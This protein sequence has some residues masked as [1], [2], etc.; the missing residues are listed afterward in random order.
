MSTWQNSMKNCSSVI[1][2]NYQQCYHCHYHNLSYYAGGCFCTKTRRCICRK[3][4][5]LI[6]I[7]D[8]S[9]LGSNGHILLITFQWWG[10]AF[11]SVHSKYCKHFKGM[12]GVS[13]PVGGRY[14]ASEK[15]VNNSLSSSVLLQS[16]WG[17]TG[18]DEANPTPASLQ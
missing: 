3:W 7:I 5:T 11:F 1:Y 18:G 17:L 15:Q 4:R 16:N 9:V 13:K 10:D 6:I 14:I 12:R 8:L 2:I